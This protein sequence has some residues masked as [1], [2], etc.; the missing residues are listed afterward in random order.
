MTLTICEKQTNRSWIHYWLR[1]A[2]KATQWLLRLLRLY[3]DWFLHLDP[4]SKE[5]KARTN[6][7]KELVSAHW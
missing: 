6:H 4:D 2:E 3:D 7:I 1:S 5:L